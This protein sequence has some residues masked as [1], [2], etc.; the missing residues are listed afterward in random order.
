MT[1]APQLMRYAEDQLRR[2]K[3]VAATEAPTGSRPCSGC[4][5]PPNAMSNLIVSMVI[6]CQL[7]HGRLPVHPKCPTAFDAVAHPLN[8]LPECR[9]C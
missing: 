6:H 7:A 5:L 8:G 9:L 3:S 2:L 1:A 4:S